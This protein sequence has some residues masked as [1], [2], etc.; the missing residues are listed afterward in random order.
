MLNACKLYDVSQFNFS[1]KSFIKLGLYLEEKHGSYEK[2]AISRIFAFLK[3]ME[4]FQ[5]TVFRMI[6]DDIFI[7]ALSISVKHTESFQQ[8]HKT[9]P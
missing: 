8:I 5:N 4:K 6:V 2:L 7:M 1:R 3:G 9:R